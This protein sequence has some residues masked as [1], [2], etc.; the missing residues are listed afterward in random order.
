MTFESDAIGLRRVRLTRVLSWAGFVGLYLAYGGA[1]L[2]LDASRAYHGASILLTYL[3]WLVPWTA[4]Y[5]LWFQEPRKPG[6]IALAEDGVVRIERGR[7]VRV[8]PRADIESAQSILRFGEPRV[9]IVLA[10]GDVFSVAVPSLPDADALV[11]RLG[12][13][14]GGRRQRFALGARKRRFLHLAVGFGA[15]Q[16]TSIAAMPL[17][18]LVMFANFESGF[19]LSM[20]AIGIALPFVYRLFRSWIRE[21]RIEIGDDGMTILRG[22]NTTRFL[23]RTDVFGAQVLPPTGNIALNTA[24][25]PVTVNATA[26]DPE[27][28]RA[29]L[30][31]MEQ[32]WAQVNQ[33]PGPRVAAFE[34]AGRPLAAWRGELALKIANSGYRGDTIT[35]EE[36]DA[37]VRNANASPD[38]R[39]GAA[40]ALA[41]AGERTRVAGAAA[42]IAEQRLRVALEAV[43][44]GRDEAELVE[45][46]LLQR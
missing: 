40:L 12:F 26:L 2:A 43:A 35:V 19:S 44:E 29:A 14:A 7:S 41:A 27:V 31:A 36:A 23:A 16:A 46:A 10:K 20:A 15:Y 6:R 18:F 28:S 3:C 25:G 37:V 11:A 30:H 34:R 9:E 32:R 8:L 5:I 17:F 38:A 24:T 22:R 33:S 13:G 21:P 1:Q 45:K 39:I 42:P 4:S